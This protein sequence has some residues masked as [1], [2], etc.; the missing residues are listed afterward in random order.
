MF[1]YYITVDYYIYYYIYITLR[2]VLST[3]NM[4]VSIEKVDT[5]QGM[6][7]TDLTDKLILWIEIVSF[8]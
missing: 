7:V 2:Q 6:S 4:N 5:S 8:C 1:T 3:K